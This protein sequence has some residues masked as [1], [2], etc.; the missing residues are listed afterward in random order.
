MEPK[1]PLDP[2]VTAPP[3]EPAA[4]AAPTEPQTPI[5]QE[6]TPN[7]S[8]PVTNPGGTN[9]QTVP[10]DRFQE[11]NDKA[12]AA[13]AKA[14]ELEEENERLRN[15]EPASSTNPQNNDDELD[16]EVEALIRKGAKKLGLVSQD[17]LAAARNRDQVQQDIND[18]TATPP[19]AGIPYDNKT[20]MDY[21]KANNLPVT[22]KNALV[23]AY[24]SANWDKILE[25]E[26]QRAIDGYKTGGSSGAERPGSTGATPPVEPEITGKSTK[27]RTRERIRNARQKLT[28]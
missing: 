6:P 28:V 24:K 20:V 23:A 3:A 9:E 1:T 5:A 4:P 16:P 7:G 13:E 17:D 15:P 18:L 27:E 11:V 22:S 12:K 19:V 25:A 2:G 14:Q 8:E 26:R 10:F 21:A